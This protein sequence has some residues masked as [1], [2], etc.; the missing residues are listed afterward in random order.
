MQYG[1]V[2]FRVHFCEFD[3]LRVHCAYVD[4]T[5]I[6]PTCNVK[7]CMNIRYTDTVIE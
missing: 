7:G 3:M 6:T 4:S 1:A 2:N 5:A